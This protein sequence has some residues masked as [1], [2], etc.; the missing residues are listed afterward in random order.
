MTAVVRNTGMLAIGAIL[1]FAILRNITRSDQA[2][3]TR[4]ASKETVSVW[5]GQ[6][7]DHEHSQ[8]IA[9]G[10]IKPFGG[11]ATAIQH[12]DGNTK[13]NYTSAS[14]DAGIALGYATHDQF[15]RPCNGYLAKIEIDPRSTCFI[16]MKD[17]DVFNEKEVLI[18]GMLKGCPVMYVT[19]RTTV[20]EVYQ[21]LGR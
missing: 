13:S 21:T 17:D 8:Y 2:T 11:D 4:S 20:A 7:E 5:R 18:K 3:K 12:R 19:P 10:I 1:T 14:Y 15:G 6:F 16:D 9:E